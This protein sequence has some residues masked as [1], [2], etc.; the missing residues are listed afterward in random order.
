GSAGVSVADGHSGDR[1]DPRARNAGPSPR[2]LAAAGGEY[3][4]LL[5]RRRPVPSL[6]RRSPP[7]PAL[8]SGHFLPD[9]RRRS[10]NRDD[11][12]SPHGEVSVG[13]NPGG[14]RRHRR[15]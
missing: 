2:P 13:S 4:V 15:S 14:T 9:P 6:S 8:D 3:L 11:V 12:L 1:N 10:W 7:P 5:D